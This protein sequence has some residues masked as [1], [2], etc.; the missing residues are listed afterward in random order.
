M[1]RRRASDKKEKAIMLASSLL[2]LSAM[3]VTGFAIYNDSQSQEEEDGYYVDFSALEEGEGENAAQVENQSAKNYT[4]KDSD[5]TAGNNTGKTENAPEG[6]LDYDPFYQEADRILNEPAAAASAS[7]KKSE[8]SDSAVSGNDKSTDTS[9]SDPQTEESS[10]QALAETLSDQEDLAEEDALNTAA[11]AHP[12]LSFK[13]DEALAWPIVGNVLIN[14]SMD[15]TVYFATLDQYKY[16][17][18]IC[19]AAVQGTEITAAADGIVKEVYKDAQIGNAVVMELGDG[20]EITYGQLS[21][22][23]VKEGEYVGVGKKIG[24][25]AAPTKYYSVEGTNVYFKL[26]KDGEPV[27]PLNRLG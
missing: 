14:Y 3:T 25:V 19:I 9:E 23:T 17:P 2:V 27:N 18:A 26:T 1:K 6:E 11:M 8:E 24:R 5:L 10:E 15:K 16:S 20:Y 4:S 21:D 13:D 7:G 22:I 12:E